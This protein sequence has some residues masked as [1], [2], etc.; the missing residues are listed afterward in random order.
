MTA[1]VPI[2][3]RFLTGLKRTIFREARLL[4]SWDA[5]GRVSAAW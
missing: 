1:S 5:D 2:Q 3:F 4:G